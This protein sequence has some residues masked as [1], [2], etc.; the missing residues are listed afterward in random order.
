MPI[1]ASLK[2]MLRDWIV[3]MG[4]ITWGRVAVILEELTFDDDVLAGGGY[5]V[6]P[7]TNGVH[8]RVSS[9]MNLVALDADQYAITLWERV[10]Q[11]KSRVLMTQIVMVDE[12]P[13]LGDVRDVQEETM[14]RIK[15]PRVGG[16]VAV[17]AKTPLSPSR[18]FEV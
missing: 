9:V 15:D 2:I 7:R 18:V 12:E 14:L 13:E 11:M 8:T 17:A 10:K 4:E 1:L 6:T 16:M 3:H 5:L